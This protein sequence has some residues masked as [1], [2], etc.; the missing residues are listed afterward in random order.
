MM[1]ARAPV[2]DMKGYTFVMGGMSGSTTIRQDTLGGVATDVAT[3][4]QIL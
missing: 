1:R 3:L 4:D 2:L